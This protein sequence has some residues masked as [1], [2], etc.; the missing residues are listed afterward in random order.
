MNATEFSA[1]LVL[2]T[3]TSFTPGPNTTLSTALAANH[4]LPRAL[5]FVCAVPVGWAL[6]LALCTA[7]V[8]ALVMA[9]PLLRWAILG[10]G[11]VYLLWLAGRLWCSRALGQADD[12]RLQ[13]GFGQGVA[14]QFLNIKAWML[15]LSIVAGWIAGRDDAWQRFAQVLPVM[16]AFAFASNLAYALTGSLLREWLAGPVIDGQ[17]SGRRLLI[18]NRAMAT[19]LVLTAAWML[20]HGAGAP[21]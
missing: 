19:A 17:P 12:A 1:L 13:V 15:A 8:G 18:F 20:A 3:A 14:L 11:G 7:G 9:Q 16:L 2:A 21:A 5:R 4:G 6:L 10:G